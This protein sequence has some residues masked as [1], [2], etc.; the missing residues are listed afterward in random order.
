[1]YEK[2]YIFCEKSNKYI[3]NSRTRET[4][5][6]ANELRA[7]KEVQAVAT[8]RM[9]EKIL[10]IT[11]RELVAAEVHY[12]K[13]CYRDYTRAY[14]SKSSKVVVDDDDQSYSKIESDAFQMLFDSIRS[15]LF[16]SPRIVPMMDLIAQLVDFMKD[17]EVWLGTK[18]HT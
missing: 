10:A 13:T 16:T 14:Y 9:D 18:K 11:L 15:D 1:M 17:H 7:D 5:V 12:H 6:Q 4:L 8:A 2:T 3:K